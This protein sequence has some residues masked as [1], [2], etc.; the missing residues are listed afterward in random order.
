MKKSPRISESEWAVMRVLW[1]RAPR[2]ANEVVAAL[3]KLVDWNPRTIKTLL[4]RLVTKRALGYRKEGR[5]Y[6]YHPLV[7]ESHCARAE[8]RSLLRRVYGGALTPMLAQFIEDE[9]LSK[10]EI[11]ELKAILDRKGRTK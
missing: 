11:E 6:L 2:S 8:R 1:E 4:N 9:D 7:D 3:E 10:S 5:S